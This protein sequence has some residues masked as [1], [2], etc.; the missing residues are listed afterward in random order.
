MFIYSRLQGQINS[1]QPKTITIDIFDT[2]LLRRNRAEQWHFWRFSKV[3][4]KTLQNNSISCSALLYFSLRN[5][6]NQVLRTVNLDLGYDYE[7]SLDSI[8]EAIIKEVSRRRGKKLTLAYRKDLCKK[9][10]QAEI[11]F[12][13]EHLFV[14]KKLVS[15][16]E[17]N[18]VPVFFVTDMY[19][20]SQ[21]I[22]QLLKVFGIQYRGISS[23]DHLH[24]KSSGRSFA[25]LGEKF[26]SVRLT[27]NLHIGD[28]RQADI[29]V[30]ERLGMHVFWLNL[31]L[32][33]LR[34][35][36]TKYFFGLVVKGISANAT[37]KE[38]NKITKPLFAQKKTA[39]TIGSMFAPAIIYY[40]HYLGSIS[41][42]K[43]A[44]V[45]FVSSESYT[46]SNF[47][48]QLGFRNYVGLPKFS[49]SRL[50]RSYCYLQHR[51][52]SRYMSLLP[53][54]KKVQRR[55]TTFDALTTLG[56]VS[57]NYQYQLTG[58]KAFAEY[59]DKNDQTITRELK[60]VYTQT[61][62]EFARAAKSKDLSKIILAD[63]GWNSTIQ[64]LLNDILLDNNYRNVLSGI[65]LGQTGGNVFNPTIRT[66][67]QGLLFNNLT[68][69]NKYLYQPEVWESF[70]NTDNAGHP[71]REQ[72]LASITESIAFYQIS[73]LSPQDYY[74]ASKK[75]L[76]KIL[77]SPN[78]WIIQIFA[79]LQFDYGT[80]NET[81][82]PLVDTSHSPLF[83]Y[84]LL[85]RDRARFKQFYHDNGW[86]WG[87][88]S[89]YHF[90]LLYRL[91]RRKTKK[92]SF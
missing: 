45:A 76:I 35:L 75:N 90:R 74:L 65:Y 63:V 38:Y 25:R 51:N 66:N 52:G 71:T 83:A 39:S 6:Y 14:N 87:A 29:A 47:Y 50:I 69:T 84:R 8:N 54:I 42:T 44:K 31:P 4:A 17:N 40:T 24:G 58:K 43:K 64:I 21:Q 28:H 61:V 53:M 37:R 77:A 5:Y 48:T 9:L 55:K 70:L 57:Q 32:H 92:P 3:A 27:T 18:K 91:W 60:K 85:L 49:R 34:L 81:P 30:P 26:S 16:L 72:I 88:A 2:L 82:V 67:S 15:V 86:K 59:L 80:G 41:T 13:K 33:R 20:D 73:N 12:E 19:F 36:I 89:W 7:A 11:K 56:A 62:H 46:L 78:R 10:A 68:G 22:R 1:I 79:R 23:A